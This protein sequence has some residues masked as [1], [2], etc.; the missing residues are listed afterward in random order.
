MAGVPETKAKY[1]KIAGGG[2]GSSYNIAP[3]YNGIKV[4]DGN[5]PKNLKI[6]SLVYQNEFDGRPQITGRILKFYNHCALVDIEESQTLTEFELR[7]MNYRTVI[8]YGD[9]R[10]MG[11]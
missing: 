3:I 10:K 2:K 11:V 9:I 5:I 1:T 7:D 8:R 4:E 6:H